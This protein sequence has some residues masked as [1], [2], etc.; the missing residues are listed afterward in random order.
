MG[1]RKYKNSKK[2]KSKNNKVVFHGYNGNKYDAEGKEQDISDDENGDETFC[3]FV[4]HYLRKMKT[5][6]KT[7]KAKEYLQNFQNKNWKFNKNN[8]NFILKFILYEKIFPNEYFEIFK[9]YLVNMHKGTKDK[10]IKQCEEFIKVYN[11]DINKDEK[12]NLNINGHDLKFS[13]IE[14]KKE[15][16]NSRHNRCV[17]LIENN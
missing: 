7:E 13:D 14:K 4:S 12:L 16:L 2:K 15:I 3:V 11:E 6:K 1:K 17:T 9:S 10:F 8:Q 5:S